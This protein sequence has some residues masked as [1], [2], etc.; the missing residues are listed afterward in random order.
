MNS[1]GNWIFFNVARMLLFKTT[2]LRYDVQIKVINKYQS[3]LSPPRA[4]DISVFFW[5]STT[6]HVTLTHSRQSTSL[7]SQSHER[8]FCNAVDMHIAKHMD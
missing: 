8:Y 5:M 3:S 2:D 4:L 1:V 7:S 6:G